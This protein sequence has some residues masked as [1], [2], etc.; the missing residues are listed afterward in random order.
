[1]SGKKI[2]NELSQ[3]RRSAHVRFLLRQTRKGAP[4]KAL[5]KNNHDET[6]ITPQSYEQ[7]DYVGH[8]MLIPDF[9][10]LEEAEFVDI[11]DVD[12]VTA[13]DV[14]DSDDDD[15]IQLDQFDSLKI[16]QSGDLSS[17]HVKVVSM[18]VSAE[19][20]HCFIVII[21]KINRVKLRTHNLLL[22]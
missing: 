16:S 14:D 18:V 22:K 19:S 12:S 11:E 9:N 21:D 10:E 17:Q 4:F 6:D 8:N 20:L 1:M 13:E 15:Y 3:E 2:I 7:D 5:R